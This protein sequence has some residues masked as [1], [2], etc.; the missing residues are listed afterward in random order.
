[1]TCREAAYRHPTRVGPP[2]AKTYSISQGRVF[3]IGGGKA[4]GAMA[5]VLEDILSPE[6]ITAGIVNCN[7][8]GYQTAKIKINAAS[9][10]TPDRAGIEGVKRMLALISRYSINESDLIIC[11]ISGG[12]S[13]LL[14]YPVDEITL[15][16]KQEITALLLKS[17][18]T[19]HEINAVRKHLSQIKGGRLGRF[20]S[21]ARVV[22]LILSDVIGNDLDVI[23]SGPT[24][25]DKSTFPDALKVLEKYNLLSKAP[26][27]VVEFLK[28]GCAGEIEETPKKLDNCDNFI[29]GDNRLALEAMAE[30]ARTL[31][32]KPY[33]VSAAQQGDPGEAAELRA[34]EILKG[35]YKGY[36]VLLVGGETTPKLPKDPGKGGRNRH[37][38]AASLSALQDYPGE[39]VMAA[40]GTD[41]ADFLPDAA[42]A[43]VDRISAV[44]LKSKAPGGCTLS[45]ASRR[46]DRDRTAESKSID[47]RSYLKRYDSSTLFEKIGDS[48]IRTGGTGTNAGDVAVYLLK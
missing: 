42:G 28:R 30:K 46:N 41:G 11:L 44:R 4:S 45:T 38:A 6:N 27:K 36:D 35:K 18:P 29:I 16:E 13:A 26:P 22:S 3:V 8:T 5:E 20:F 32:F 19:I 2:E 7:S 21:P 9:H 40:V 31:G 43:I 34:K 48:L 47:I 37:F 17:G 1:G 10:P 39:W 15:A 12:G 24:A 14:P 23:A 33:I 25:P